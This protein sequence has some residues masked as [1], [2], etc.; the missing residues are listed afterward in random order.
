MKPAVSTLMMGV[1]AQTN[2]SGVFRMVR[3]QHTILTTQTFKPHVSGV[4]FVVRYQ[5][6]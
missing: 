2:V 6:S 1:E 4:M 3:S 5:L